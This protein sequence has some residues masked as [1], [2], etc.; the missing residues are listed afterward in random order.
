M[1]TTAITTWASPKPRA[2]RDGFDMSFERGSVPGTEELCKADAIWPA[3]LRRVVRAIL[4][5]WGWPDLVETAELLLTELV[6]NAL[7]YGNGNDVGVR[8]YLTGGKFVM[9]VR[10]GSSQR[11]VL[12][13]ATHTEK[14]GRGLLIVDAM[15]EEW[16]VSPDGT[17]TWCTLAVAKGRTEVEAGPAE[18]TSVL[19]EAFLRLPADSSAVSMA[20]IRGRML[21][22]VLS[23][24]GN[25]S[26]AIDVLYVLV[27]N[28]LQHGGLSEKTGHEVGVW[29]RITK[30][31][32]L[33][34]DVTDPN[35]SFP[36]FEKAVNGELGRGLV[37]A[38]RLGAAI[39]WFPGSSH[40]KTVRATMRQ[41]RVGL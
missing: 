17:T 18:T 39:T 25:Q 36:D 21:L 38:Q 4:Q 19:H 20:R 32:D 13:R 33:L 5:H 23:W 10:D 41:G 31:H 2:V 26:D 29:F 7:R 12:R 11:P 27:H 15:A 22:T 1:S 16:G 6:T 24:H 9:E 34:I 3:R 35:P 28:A 8:L 30:A 40:G 14:N 37:G